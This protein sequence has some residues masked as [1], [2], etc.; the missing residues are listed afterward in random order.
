MR[1]AT[2]C[3]RRNEKDMKC[4]DV[5]C[6]GTPTQGVNG[7]RDPDVRHRWSR[8]SGCA[9]GLRL[10]GWRPGEAWSAVSQPLGEERDTADNRERSSL[11]KRRGRTIRRCGDNAG[12]ELAERAIVFLVDA[13]AAGRPMIFD[14]GTNR[15]RYCIARRRRVDDTDDA[16][17][18][19]LRKPGDEDPATNES[20]NA[21]T[22]SVVSSG[23]EHRAI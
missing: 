21:T 23:R 4:L 12:D 20:R 17:Q 1:D 18:N 3:T 9:D 6:H 7:A 19:R 11:G 8:G 15:G 16:R 5:G 14:V 22:H 10:C 2:R 13:R